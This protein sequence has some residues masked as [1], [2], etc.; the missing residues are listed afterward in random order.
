MTKGI[1]DKDKHIVTYIAK[2][3]SLCPLCH[4]QV[5]GHRVASHYNKA[6]HMQCYEPYKL[7]YK[8]EKMKEDAEKAKKEAK[9]YIGNLLDMM[10]KM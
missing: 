5:K 6:C 3:P 4:K 8:A 10:E 7:V 1:T 9:Q 2:K